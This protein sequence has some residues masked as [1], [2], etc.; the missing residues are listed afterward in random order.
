MKAPRVTLDQWRTLQAV[1]DQ[2]GYAQAAEFLHRS[3]SSV[4]YTIAKLQEQLGIPLLSIEGRK[5]R[6]TEAGEV[7]LRRSRR[8]VQEAAQLEELAHTIGCGWEPEIRLVVDVAFPA[9]VLMQALSAFAP[10]SRGTQVQLQEV[11]LSGA[12]DALQSGE[13]DLAI[14][15]RVPE[16]FLGD[17]L[18]DIEF[19]AV[20]RPDHPLH[21]L[22]RELNVSDLLHHIQVVIRDSGE[23]DR[24]EGWLGA[25]NRWTVTSI[26]TALAATSHGLGFAWLPRHTIE[27]HLADGRLR[28]LPLREGQ[29]G[30]GQL[31]LVYGRSDNVGPATQKLAEI[32]KENVAQHTVPISETGQA[33]AEA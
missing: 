23:Q 19:V 12:D 3:Q 16:N 14:C 7:L 26:E 10:L 32:I 22:G 13:A 33:E 21:Q 6:L 2:G 31:Y 17:L 9:P 29:I 30:Y 5:A 1:V 28:P 18:V 15:T 20:A 25:E 24:N 8:L 11:V 27:R 4:S